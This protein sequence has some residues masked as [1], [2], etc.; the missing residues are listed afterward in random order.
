MD[1]LRKKAIVTFRF[2]GLNEVVPFRFIGLTNEF[3]TIHF[4]DVNR[5]PHRP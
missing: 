3:I 1:Y 4:V 5:D 2:I